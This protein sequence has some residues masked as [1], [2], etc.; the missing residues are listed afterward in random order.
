LFVFGI[1]VISLVVV[2][3]ILGVVTLIVAPALP[4]LRTTP[5]NATVSLRTFT[6]TFIPSNLS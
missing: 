4:Q 6:D 1:V 3:I 5:L 2:L